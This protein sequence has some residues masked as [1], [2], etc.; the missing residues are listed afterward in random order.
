MV[1]L[2]PPLSV[3]PDGAPRTAA[4]P[5][6]RLPAEARRH[7]TALLNQQFWLW[8]HDIR[9]PEG[10]ALLLHGFGQE[11]PPE[12][13][14]G[15]TRYDLALDPDRVVVL[16]GFGLFYGDRALGGVA[17]GRF[18]L[19]PLFGD[20]DPPRGVWETARL[21]RFGPPV[22]ADERR[23]T[24]ALLV[25]ALRWIAAYE[26]WAE[27]ALDSSHRQR[28]LAAWRRPPCPRGETAVAWTRLAYRCHASVSRA[29]RRAELDLDPDRFPSA[30]GGPA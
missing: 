24:G 16:W 13:L 20:P 7:G 2:R 22:G 4:V 12:G 28:S 21:P 17:L 9:R 25:A 6:L 8:G 10:N 23:R 11:R 27:D 29:N 30:D 1:A 14:R 3:R 18:R 15:S 26:A 5:G 19:A